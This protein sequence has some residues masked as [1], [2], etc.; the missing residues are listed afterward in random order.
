MSS[1]EPANS[2]PAPSTE[3][4]NSAPAP[5]CLLTSL[6]PEIRLQIYQYLLLGAIWVSRGFDCHCRH[7]IGNPP[8]CELCIF[9]EQRRARCAP[10]ILRTSK[11]IYNDLQPLFNTMPVIVNASG[12]HSPREGILT[13][14]A[15]LPLHVSNRMSEIYVQSD[16]G[17]WYYFMRRVFRWFDF[18]AY[19]NL[20]NVWMHRLEEVLACPL[21]DQALE[22]T[23]KAALRQDAPPSV[24]RI[25]VN[26]YAFSH[27]TEVTQILDTINEFNIALKFTYAMTYHI[28]PRPPVRFLE[29]PIAKGDFNVVSLSFL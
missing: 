15:A 13:G 5:F 24:L 9:D 12:H 27:E 8:R 7:C 26:R 3:P 18:G 16:D 25:P 22:S 4:A 21:G 6:P 23:I 14:K 11:F 29:L 17:Y 10:S 28:N 19:P 20:R 1:T 2:A